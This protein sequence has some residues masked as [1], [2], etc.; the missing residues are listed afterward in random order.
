MLLRWLSSWYSSAALCSDRRGRSMEAV[1]PCEVLSLP[2]QELGHA[3]VEEMR[4]NKV[5]AGVRDLLILPILQACNW[6]Y[7]RVMRRCTINLIVKRLKCKRLN[8]V[9]CAH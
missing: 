1:L 2:T 4:D 8:N 7:C 3:C 6:P 9:Y 5:A